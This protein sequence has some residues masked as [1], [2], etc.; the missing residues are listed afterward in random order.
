M[1][2]LLL[3]KFRGFNIILLGILLFKTSATYTQAKN[4]LA[5]SIA[6]KMY[7]YGLQKP[8]SLLFVHFDKNIYTNK[9]YVWFSGYLLKS[10]PKEDPS[11][12]SVAL[13][14]NDDR[15][16]LAEGKFVMNAGLSFGNLYIPDS[17]PSGDYSFVCY[18]N[19]LPNGNPT[20]VFI[21][22]VT[23]KD[24]YEPGF[25]A[26]LSLLDS[27]NPS[28]DNVRV[29]VKAYTTEIAL[30]KDAE[31]SYFIGD[32][33]NPL[34]S[35]KLKTN[36]FGEATIMIPLKGINAAN[37]ILQ[38]EINTGKE[39]QAFNIKLPVYNKEA[40][41]KFYPEGGHLVNG[42]TNVVGWEATTSE[43]E[44][45]QLKGTLYKD[46]KP[47]STLST[48]PYGM[49]K[50]SIVPEEKCS[51]HV[52]LKATR[53]ARDS[54]TYHLPV[55]VSNAPVVSIATA[56]TSDTLDIQLNAE[57]AGS[58]WT[59]MIHNFTK[60][61]VASPIVSNGTTTKIKV[62]LAAVPNGLNAFTLLDSAGRPWVER[63]FF[64]HFNKRNRIEIS[65]NDT[66]Y[67]LRQKVEVRFKITDADSKPLVGLVSVACA[68]DNR[69]DPRKMTDIETYS[70]LQHELSSL[71]FRTRW[72]STAEE[73]KE[74]LENLLL[75]RGWRRYTWQDMVKA[76]AN[77]TIQQ[78]AELIY[79]GEVINRGKPI[80]KQPRVDFLRPPGLSTLKVDTLGNFVIPSARL[81]LRPDQ[82]VR[83]FVNDPKRE[84]Y[85][86]RVTDPYKELAKKI[87]SQLAYNS[88]T[89]N[90]FEK[91]NHVVT[92]NDAVKGKRL[93]DVVVG[94]RKD[95]NFAANI[96]GDYVCEA[97][98]LNCPNHLFGGSEPVVGVL[99][100]TGK[101]RVVYTGCEGMKYLKQIEGIYTNKE[102]YVSDYSNPYL[103]GTDQFST[104]YWNHSVRTN[105]K[106]E[107]K[108]TFSTNDLPG[109]F[110]ITIQGF[111][112]KN[113][114]YGEQL[115]NVKKD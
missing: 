103:E 100:N 99:Y 39:M 32:R 25:V 55:A 80:T 12:M 1:P 87:T 8:S 109:K 31:V 94:S 96:C 4:S 48:N 28:L 59:I 42:K 90:A 81:V 15:S 58:R 40:I 73:N 3:M 43:G 16:V 47:V 78:L 53:Q 63:L 21:Q 51:Y 102:F 38:T 49:G 84:N 68:Q 89:T 112:T 65:T 11:A 64:A 60:Q 54:V 98:V 30:L 101:G 19:Y 111:T 7:W 33:M 26:N 9:E 24:A 114:V 75:V 107:G 46:D 34:R 76:N 69:Y 66:S 97:N 79:K 115:L 14:R 5:D 13:V 70:Y 74:Y 92:I 108:L 71:P 22:P 23:I 62:A 88:Y 61:F 50:F 36:N 106:G 95:G 93:L 2:Y 104:M 86:I 91:T 41:V 110:R 57:H 52:K 45:L 35:G 72:L 20:D 77:D 105:D 44:P 17:L 85:V 83:V 82:N 37:N 67:R 29:L 10:R 113:V 6:K 56:L 18:T 27:L